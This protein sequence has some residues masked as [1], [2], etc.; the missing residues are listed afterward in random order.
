MPGVAVFLDNCREVGKWFNRGDV[1]SWIDGLQNLQ[2][3]PAVLGIGK[4]KQIQARA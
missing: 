4:L 3:I 1:I 2:E